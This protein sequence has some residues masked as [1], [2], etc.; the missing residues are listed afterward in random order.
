M[1]PED[2]WICSV[3]PGQGRND[4]I[5]RLYISTEKYKTYELKFDGNNWIVESIVSSHVKV[6]SL[7]D[8]RGDGINR[9]YGVAGDSL[10]EITYTQNGWQE[11]LIGIWPNP[12]NF[13]HPI[14]GF[15][16]P[17]LYHFGFIGPM[18]I[19]KSIDDRTFYSYKYNS[20]TNSWEVKAMHPYYPRYLYGMSYGFFYPFDVMQDPR[21]YLFKKNFYAPIYPED[22]E[23]GDTIYIHEFSYNPSTKTWTRKAISYI[24]VNPGALSCLK[25]GNIRGK[26][27]IYAIS[28]DGTIVEISYE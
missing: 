24:T 3:I 11:N 15:A 5:N 8:G 16:P 12:Q 28:E 19:V 25:C 6:G 2:K 21:T 27:C 20:E 10:F 26:N 23:H 7:G 9:L 17:D 13:F 18:I 22:V 14:G 4:G 1:A